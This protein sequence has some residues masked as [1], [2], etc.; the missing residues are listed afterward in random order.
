MSDL[1]G[2]RMPG[3]TGVWVN[4]RKVAAIGVRAQRWVT[5]H[6]MSLNV[7]M[8]LAPFEMIVP[9]GISGAQ[10]LDQHGMCGHAPDQ[11]QSLLCLVE[12]CLSHCTTQRLDDCDG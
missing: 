2:Q 5:Y 3:L 12:K 9:C 7:D 6:G 11:M 1:N 8:D 10:K 4:G